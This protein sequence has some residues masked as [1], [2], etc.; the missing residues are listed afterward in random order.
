MPPHPSP[1]PK[2]EGKAK[3]PFL[4]FYRFLTG[5]ALNDLEKKMSAVKERIIDIVNDQPDDSS[6]DDILHALALDR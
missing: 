2:G 6:F 3:H 5:A 4:Q 1:L